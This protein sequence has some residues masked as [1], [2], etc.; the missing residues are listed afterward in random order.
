MIRKNR[1]FLLALVLLTLLLCAA[2]DSIDDLTWDA[3]IDKSR[4]SVLILAISSS[5]KGSLPRTDF[6]VDFFGAHRKLG[7][8]I[9]TLGPY[10]LSA[11]GVYRFEAAVPGKYASAVRAQPVKAVSEPLPI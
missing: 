8:E 9:Y 10:K 4:P 1:F 5:Q 3:A 2:A 11:A 6:V 7:H